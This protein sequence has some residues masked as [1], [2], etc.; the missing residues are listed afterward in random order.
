LQKALKILIMFIT[1]VLF[2]M[3]VPPAAN[4]C[5]CVE[6]PSV[7]EEFARS[8]A[9]FSGKA[10]KWMEEEDVSFRANHTQKILFEVQQNWKGASKSQMIITTGSGGGDCG[11]EFQEGEDYLIYAKPSEMYGSQEDLVTIICDRTTE[12]SEADED[13]QVLGKGKPPAEIVD[14]EGKNKKGPATLL[15][16]VPVAVILL[17][18]AVFLLMK[19]IKRK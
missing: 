18:S 6:P 2:T 14:L 12:L 4:A 7:K 13:L 19:K 15:W 8:Q 16:I 10:I 9:V 17:G 11:I 5:S 3:T 1:L